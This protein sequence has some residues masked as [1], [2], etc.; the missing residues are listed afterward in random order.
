M[1]MSDVKVGMRLKSTKQYDIFSPIIVT[2]LTEKGFKYT[3][4]PRTIKIGYNGPIPQFGT[5]SGGEHYAV[6]GEVQY[7]EITQTDFSI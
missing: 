2:E 6:G 1:K 5:C 7:E 3:C 4:E